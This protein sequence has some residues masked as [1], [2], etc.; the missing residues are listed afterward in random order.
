M[1]KAK[2]VYTVIGMCSVSLCIAGW[3]IGYSQPKQ[4]I[5]SNEVVLAE[6]QL[7]T[8]TQKVDGYGSLVSVNQRLITA[9]NTA[10]VDEILLEPGA[11]VKNNS[12][13][14][15]LKNPQLRQKLQV[16]QN[17]LQ[18][19]ITDRSKQDLIQQRELLE[20]ESV[21]ADIKAEVELAQLQVEAESILAKSGIVSAMDFKRTQVRHKQL[22]NRS[23]LLQ[24]R[25][26]KLI[27][28]HLQQLKLMDDAINQARSEFESVQL[29]F[30]NLE[31]KAG[32][33]G[34]LQRLPVKLG[35]TVQAGTELA[36]VGS[37]NPLIAK[38]KVPQL[39]A[40]LINVG[41]KAEIDSRNGLISGHVSRIDPVVEDGA[42]AI[43]I[44][45]T[46]ELNHNLKPMQ[47]VDAVI[48]GQGRQDVL[49]LEQP[50]SILAESSSTVFRMVDMNNAQKVE[51]TFGKTSGRL[52]EVKQ[53]LKK[54]DKI[55]TSAHDLYPDTE[56]LQIT[57]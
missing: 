52:I 42:V 5:K 7:G 35:Q 39:Q 45:L 22:L 26:D 54:G 27:S 20:Q 10:T 53:G 57:Q 38:I 24:R 30:G 14:L 33:N 56:S 9:D 15:K 25:L 44:A 50:S 48:Y 3:S 31:V 28:V 41:S 40:D 6:V 17:A 1:N 49:Y 36:L 55:I 11:E 18:S 2:V 51:V 34:V 29:Q 13:I 47:V 19:A 21:L 32:I 43:D 8:F 12:I 16:T 23:N 37:V 46:M 4:F